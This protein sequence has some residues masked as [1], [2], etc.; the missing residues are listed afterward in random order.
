MKRIMILTVAA[1][2]VMTLPSFAHANLL[3]N[4]GV[5]NGTYVND[6]SLPDNWWSGSG[7]S[8]WSGKAWANEASNAHSGS[9]YLKTWADTGSYAYWG[10]N[11][12]GI[13]EGTLL[14]FSGYL[15]TE[16]WDPVSNPSAYLKIE[17]KDA[18][19]T[20]LRTDGGVTPVFTGEHGTWTQYTTISSA[21]PSGTT[22]ANFVM[23]MEGKGAVWGD[24]FNAEV[25]PEPTSMLLLGSGLIGLFGLSRRK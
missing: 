4:A 6:Q 17:F 13:S 20:T 24:D 9:K 22:N 2:M 14:S 25:V 5:E 12:T 3:S 7:G 23:Y 1:L 11:I 16:S 19:D 18:S 21:A 15:K 10:Q 8:S